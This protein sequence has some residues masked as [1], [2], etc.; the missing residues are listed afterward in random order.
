MSPRLDAR[1]G[2]TPL[3][4]V[5][6]LHWPDWTPRLAD[7]IDLLSDDERER[8]SRFHRAED[9]KRFVSCRAWLRCIL[10]KRLQAPPERI[11]FANGPYGKPGIEGKWEFNISH[12]GDWAVCAVAEDLPVGIDIEACRMAPDAEALARQ[13]F[14]PEDWRQIRFGGEALLAQR[15]L[16][17]WTRKEAFVK[18][19]GVGLFTDLACFTV[20]LDAS[21][22]EAPDDL[23]GNSRRW[24]IRNLAIAPGHAVA[25]CAPGTWDWRESSE[26]GAV[27]P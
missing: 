1:P 16:T 9:C 22:V 24:G 2:A 21:F 4:D 11:V 8:A 23:T 15:F 10:G 3:I 14:S 6:T 12:S 5:Y 26:C 20:G 7:F 25:L 18:A 19:T 17:V 27:L 13:F